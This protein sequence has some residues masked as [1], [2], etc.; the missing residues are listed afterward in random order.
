MSEK[1]TA[2]ELRRQA[3]RA[4]RRHIRS[5]PTCQGPYDGCEE[6]QRLEGY[7]ID[8]LKFDPYALQCLPELPR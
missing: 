8:V 5:C 4:L 7:C 1:L 6:G 3:A 2:A